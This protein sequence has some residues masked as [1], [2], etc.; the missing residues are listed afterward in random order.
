MVME[1][2]IFHKLILTG[3]KSDHLTHVDNYLSFH[4]IT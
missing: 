2:A 3:D 1:I 4:N